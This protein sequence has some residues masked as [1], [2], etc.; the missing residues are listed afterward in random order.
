MIDFIYITK[1][2][3]RDDLLKIK[4]GHNNESTGY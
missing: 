3:Q 1:Y 4:G 2:N